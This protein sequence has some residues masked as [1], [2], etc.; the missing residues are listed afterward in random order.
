MVNVTELRCYHQ[1][2]TP[3]QLYSTAS[4]HLE[5]GG[6]L[7]P[8]SESSIEISNSI[9]EYVT[10]A[11]LDDFSNFIVL[12]CDD[13]VVNTGVFNVVIRRIELKLQR[14]I[15]CIICLLHFNELP[16]G[17]LFEYIDA[18]TFGPSSYTGDI[19]RN[20][21][22]CEKLPLV[23]FNSIECELP[24]IDPTNVSYDQKYLLGICSA[25]G[26]DVWSSDLAKLQPGTFNLV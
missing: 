25:I 14:P 7:K 3:C 2:T 23:A 16:L 13:T 15:Q 26:S 12:G 24:G 5:K 17:H 19:G 20:L 21:Q 18:K 6:I 22:S 8:Q 4:R 1:Q 9:C 10:S 11:L